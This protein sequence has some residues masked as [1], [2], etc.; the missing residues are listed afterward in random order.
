MLNIHE[1]LLYLCSQDFYNKD[2]KYKYYD[3]NH[4]NDNNHHNT[5]NNSSRDD[6]S[7]YSFI[8]SLYNCS[9]IHGWARNTQI[10]ANKQQTTASPKQAWLWEVVMALASAVRISYHNPLSTPRWI[11][12]GGHTGQV[13]NTSSGIVMNEVGS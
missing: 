3:D 7:S 2:I 1:I 5:D 9:A 6:T 12:S 13:R 11:N 10:Q 8:L 4:D